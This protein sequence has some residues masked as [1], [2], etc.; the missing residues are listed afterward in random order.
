M[1][2][3][4][5]RKKRKFQRVFHPFEWLKGCLHIKMYDSVWRVWVSLVTRFG[6]N[7]MKITLSARYPIEA[8]VVPPVLSF[9]KF[10]RKK[11]WFAF[12]LIHEARQTCAWCRCVRTT[13]IF[14]RFHSTAQ[15]RYTNR[16][17]HTSYQ[18]VY[19]LNY[20]AIKNGI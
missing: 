10:P 2:V 3:P 15:N 17:Q 5:R 20:K 11:T 13:T 9:N 14:I 4:M 6:I 8:Y 12:R 7:K 16:V 19:T 18:K 1:H